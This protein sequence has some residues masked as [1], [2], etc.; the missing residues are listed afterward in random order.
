MSEKVSFECDYN[1]GVVPE[2]MQRFIQTNQE[3]TS[4][5]GLDKYTH[6][7]QEKIRQA[8][9]MPQAEVFFLI[10]GTQTNATVID[11]MLMG[12]EGAITVE[13][14]HIAVHESG[15]VEAFGHKVL[16]I[17]GVDS[18]LRASDLD[19]YMRNFH[20]DETFTHMVQPRLVYIT[21]PTEFGLLYS[22][23][24][25]TDIYDTC[26]RHNLL[27]YID[28]ARLGYG[29]IADECDYNLPFLAQHCDVFYIGGT[30]V[31]ATF[32]EAV[33]FTN[34]KAPK[35]FFTTIKRHGALLAKG[36]MLGLQFDTLFTD[37]L[38]F[39]IARHAID[40]AQRMKAIFAKHNIPLAFNSPTNQQFVWLTQK[41]HDELLQHI[42]FEVW[43]R[44][45]LNQIMCR[46][47]TSWATTDKDLEALDR[48]LENLTY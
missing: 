3:K 15:A 20:E 45:D 37:N 17:P 48:A 8:V 27:L 4:G 1:N 43:E 42:A 28:G 7:A 25:L 36:R 9:G 5:Y 29:L 10:G 23:K 24:E 13:T 32:G 33:V 46:F 6:S 47:V 18:K 39:K 34:K 19:Q 35:Y 21:M 16:T 2:I 31:G 26:K 14:G 38:Y 44:Q 11:S 40:M 22:Q 41:Q 30:K 12:C